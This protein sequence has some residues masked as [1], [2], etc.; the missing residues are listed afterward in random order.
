MPA[1]AALRT[2][3]KEQPRAEPRLFHARML[4]TRVEEWCVEAATPEEARALLASGA[5]HRCTPGDTIQV[6]FDGLL[7]E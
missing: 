2:A 3:P 6:E 1:T 5:G 4:V 7:D